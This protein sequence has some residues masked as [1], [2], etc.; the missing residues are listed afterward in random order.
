MDLKVAK[1]KSMVSK[2]YSEKV[3]DIDVWGDPDIKETSG[4]SMSFNAIVKLDLSPAEILKITKSKKAF[5][6]AFPQP[7]Y[8]Q[9]MGYEDNS[10]ARE[11]IIL[12][13]LSYYLKYNITP[14]VQSYIAD[15]ICRE[16]PKWSPTVK[17]MFDSHEGYDVEEEDYKKDPRI[18]FLLT[19]MIEG[20]LLHEWLDKKKTV[21]EIKS[22]IF[23]VLY[24]AWQFYL[25]GI[26]HNDIHMGNIIVTRGPG[27][28]LYFGANGRIV[29]VNGNYIAKII[30]YD[31]AGFFDGDPPNTV[32]NSVCEE[33][34]A[35]PD[36][37]NR[38]AD[39]LRFINGI[40]GEKNSLSDECIAYLNSFVNKISTEPEE[41]ISGRP[42][43][44]MTR[45][46]GIPCRV[47]KGKGD[48]YNWELPS[49]ILMHF[50]DMLEKNVFQIE[51]ALFEELGKTNHI[52]C[53]IDVDDKLRVFL[54]QQRMHNKIDQ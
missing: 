10:F 40:Y 49:E 8:S 6:K 48:C 53:G 43:K 1:K 24:T 5:V 17:E 30:D 44:Y 41:I 23:Q 33:Y 50:P 7:F 4:T 32:W 28:P 36:G 12:R 21:D 46:G 3:C 13:Y 15:F 51:C 11:I 38:T 18:H 47:P 27:E 20:N 37:V 9:K 52:Y 34:G 16:R 31:R 45:Y 39:A 42:T 35:C 19:E 22:I 25:G 26:R 29:K 54:Q 2:N 14:C